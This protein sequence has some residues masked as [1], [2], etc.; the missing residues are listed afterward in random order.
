MRSSRSPLL[1][2]WAF[3][4]GRVRDHA[5]RLVLATVAALAL[6]AVPTAPATAYAP[7]GVVHTERVQAGPY[8]VTVG[9]S[10]WPLRAMQ[11]LDFT[12]APADGIA[13]KSGRLTIDGPGLDADDRETPLSRHPRKRDVW[14]LDVQ[15]LPESGT[16][17]FTFD[18]DGR[19]GHGRGTLRNV[20]VLDQPG[21]PLAISWTVCAIPP[22]G[23]LAYLAVGWR[24]NK[25]S[26]RVAALV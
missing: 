8:T 16:W 9:F 10:E 13:G 23:M 26:E 2:A 12:F 25:P 24:R 5:R 21:P 19:A 7:V 18:I 15:A 3:A 17:S 22:I 6:V 11:S 20:T 1:L 14:G 4:S